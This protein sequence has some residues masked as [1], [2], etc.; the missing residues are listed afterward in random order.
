MES[1]WGKIVTEHWRRHRRWLGLRPP[2]HHMGSW[3]MQW[4][5]EVGMFERLCAHGVGHPDP[6]YPLRMRRHG[7]D[8]CCSHGGDTYNPSPR[9]TIR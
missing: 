2:K 6:G 7:C 8:G 9:A 5:E 1:S 4:R 3:P